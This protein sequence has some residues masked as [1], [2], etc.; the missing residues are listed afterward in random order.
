MPARCSTRATALRMVS[1]R[2]VSSAENGSSSSI[3]LGLRA[4]ARASATRCCWPPESWCGRRVEHDAV[5]LDHVHQLG[6][7]FGRGPRFSRS[8]PKPILSATRQMRKERAVL[9][10]DADAA[11]V[12]GY[13][14]RPI[15]QRLAVQHHAARIRASRNRR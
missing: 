12:R 6:D 7:P 5:E 14:G 4:S 13:D 8:M 2:P 1:R 3:S 10:N 11:P 9:R 15:G